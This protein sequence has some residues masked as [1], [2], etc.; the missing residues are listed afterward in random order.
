MA[1]KEKPEPND[2]YDQTTGINYGE[3]GTV[4]INGSLR[5]PDDWDW[6]GIDVN[7]GDEISVTLS[8]LDIPH[9]LR[10]WYETD[11]YSSNMTITTYDPS[12]GPTTFSTP[13]PVRT[14]YSIG[15]TNL[16]YGDSDPSYSLSI[17][18]SADSVYETDTMPS[19]D[20]KTIK[21]A[22]GRDTVDAS[23]ESQG[24]KI[25]LNSGKSSYFADGTLAF[26]IASGTTIEDVN[27]TAYSDKVSG[28]AASNTLKGQ[29]GNDTLSGKGGDDKL[30]GGAGSDTMLGGSGNDK[31]IGSDG[32]DTLRGYT[33]KD[34]LS[35]GKGAD[36]FVF[37]TALANSN[38]D[39]ITDFAHGTDK[40]IL[41]DDIF[42]AL[43]IAGTGVGAPLT[44]SKFH[45]GK[46]AHDSSDRI[47]Y[48]AS[49]GALY[50]DADGS[51]GVAQQQIAII[52]TDTHP[53]LSASDFLIIA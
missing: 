45:A 23:G 40:L 42:K 49:T 25:D 31:L 48:N 41:D 18:V 1:L 43:G 22:R 2:D 20:S 14:S 37:D 52:G 39:T 10:L 30:Y 13:A 34:S 32:N 47:I 21:D 15:V 28:N 16:D 8:G 5:Y 19:L 33:G 29:G 26:R 11:G 46:S 17:R 50:Y 12:D 9:L 3:V 4:T 44:A 36:K 35:G 24:V 53:T 7:Q 6:W 27:G 38:I 51:G